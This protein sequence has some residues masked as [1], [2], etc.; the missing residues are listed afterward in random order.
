MI[1]ELSNKPR[2]RSDL[3]AMRYSALITSV[4]IVYGVTWV[5]LH[6]EA[7]DESKIVPSDSIKFRVSRIRSFS[8]KRTNFLFSGYFID[9]DF[10]WIG[11]D[12][13]LSFLFTSNK[14]QCIY[15]TSE[16]ISTEEEFLCHFD[17]LSKRCALCFRSTLHVNSFGLHSTMARSTTK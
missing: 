6:T 7:S 12:S 9:F 1:P 16:R 11:D 14:S 3:T 8:R 4:L 15:R 2:D 17:F 10:D 5:I 13:N